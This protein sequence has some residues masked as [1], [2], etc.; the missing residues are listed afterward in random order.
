MAK[1]T[2]ATGGLSD[3]AVTS[4]KITDATIATADIADDAVTKAKVTGL[5]TPAFKVLLDSAQTIADETNTVIAYDTEI[6]D[7]DS[8]V[9]S[10]VFTVPAGKGGKY[11]F[12]VNGGQ[13]HGSDVSDVNFW[14]SKNNQ[15]AIS[16]VNGESIGIEY[17]HDGTETPNYIQQLAGCFDLAAT[18]TVRV[19]H[20]HN[21]GGNRDTAIRGRMTFSGYRIAE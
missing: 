13:S 1:T 18:D 8:A 14:L 7:T 3:S 19:Y 11:A 10:G 2:I 21:Y 16:V 6:Y 5:N 12:Y 15:T 17:H 9:S 4:A 20:W